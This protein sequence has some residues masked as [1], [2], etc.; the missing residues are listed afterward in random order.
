MYVTLAHDLWETYSEWSL[1]CQRRNAR[2]KKRFLEK[3]TEAVTKCDDNSEL[4]TSIQETERFHCD[5]CDYQVNCTVAK[6][7]DVE[8]KQ[9]TIPQADGLAI[10][11]IKDQCKQI[12]WFPVKD[13]KIPDIFYTIQQFLTMLW[14]LVIAH[15]DLMDLIIWM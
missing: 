15:K 7:I 11:N 12:F 13:I 5:Q 3:E 14:V 8:K 9:K 10:P 1:S 6:R 4:E 2:R